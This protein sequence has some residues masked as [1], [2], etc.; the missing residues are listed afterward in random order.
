LLT[1][2]A[3][4]VPS[5]SRRDLRG[6]VR[7]DAHSPTALIQ[8]RFRKTNMGWLETCRRLRSTPAGYCPKRLRS[9][10]SSVL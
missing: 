1:K 4:I 3:W 6:V 10:A 9:R 8:I 2:V 5:P 7:F